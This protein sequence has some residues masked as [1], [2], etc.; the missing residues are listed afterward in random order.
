MNGILQ[1]I[2]LFAL[3]FYAIVVDYFNIVGSE[4]AKD[5]LLGAGNKSIW[6]RISTGEEGINEYKK[7]IWDRIESSCGK[8]V[9]LKPA[10]IHKLLGNFKNSLMIDYYIWAI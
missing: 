3:I 7:H 4:A 2:F 9:N 5:F 8:D 1:I 10:N 6:G